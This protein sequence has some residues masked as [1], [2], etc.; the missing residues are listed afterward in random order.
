MPGTHLLARLHITSLV[1]VELPYIDKYLSTE[2]L[3]DNTSLVGE[4][5][6]CVT[7]YGLEMIGAHWLHTS[8]K[9]LPSESTVAE[10]L[11]LEAV[12]VLEILAG[13]SSSEL[14]LATKLLRRLPIVKEMEFDKA[15]VRMMDC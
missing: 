6:C 9:A 3:D 12:L 14:S 1:L 8:Q 7:S 2:F 15:Q 4:L 5:W 10:L 13:L 11:E